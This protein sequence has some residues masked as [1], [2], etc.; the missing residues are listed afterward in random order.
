MK[1]FVLKAKKGF[2][3]VELIVVIAII[4]VL[5]AILIPIGITAFGNSDQSNTYAKNFYYAAQEVVT[6]LKLD[7]DNNLIGQTGAFMLIYMQ[8]ND[9]GEIVGDV[10]A[11]WTTTK[12][13]LGTNLS[14]CSPLKDSNNNDLSNTLKSR[15]G[16]LMSSNE[17][18]GFYYAVVDDSFRVTAAYWSDGGYTNLQNKSFTF[19]GDYQVGDY[20]CGAYPITE[21][22]KDK[23]FFN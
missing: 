5:S 4:G 9:K 10:T 15:L 23:T 1:K 11:K 12:T 19:T 21:A 2:T 16:R 22:Q 3:M 18:N 13:D 7:G 17:K 20:H 8:M 6:D 14:G